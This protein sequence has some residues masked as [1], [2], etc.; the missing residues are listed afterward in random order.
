MKRHSHSVEGI[1]RLFHGQIGPMPIGLLWT[2][3]PDTNRRDI[4]AVD[5]LKIATCDHS[6]CAGFR[7][8][9]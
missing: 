2:S 8:S 5:S 4:P 1:P 3:G 6:R 9:S 7:S